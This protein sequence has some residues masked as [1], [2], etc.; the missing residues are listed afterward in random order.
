MAIYPNNKKIINNFN[1]HNKKIFTKKKGKKTKIFLLEFNGW[2]IVHIIFSYLVNYF[3]NEKSCKIVAYES[4]NILNRVSPPWYNK[5]I[6]QLGSIIVLKTFKVFKNFGTDQFIKPK[7]S[8]KILSES[9]K[10]TEKFF[11]TNPNLQNLENL[12]IKGIWIGDLIYD[13]YLKKNLVG[14]VDIKSSNFKVFFKESINFFLFWNDFFLKNKVE[15]ICVCHSVYLTGIPLRIANHKNVSC[16]SLSNMNLVNLSKSISHQKKIN[17]TDIHFRFYRNNFNKLTKKLQNKFLT[18]GKTFLNDLI[19]GRKKYFYLKNKTYSNKIVDIKKYS[20]NN[21]RIKVV[22]FSHDFIDSPH[23]HGNHFFSDFKE[24]FKYLDTVIKKTNYD[25]FI[26]EHPA[27]SDITKKE[28]K[29]LIKNNKNLKLI[30]K[31]FPNDQINKIG[32]KFVLTVYGSVA[33]ELPALGINVI[34]ASKNNPHYGYN[35]CINPKNLTHYKSILLNLDKVKNKINL[36]DL[37]LYNSMKYHM[38]KKNYFFENNEKYFN[39]KNGK[40]LQYTFKMYDY[41]IKDFNLEK[42]KN[43]KENL[44]KFIESKKYFSFT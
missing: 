36:R 41:W 13:S 21:N 1:K 5:Y 43:I 33:S 16:F 40:P 17:G 10:I 35:F 2:P 24:W 22:I 7:Y 30:K 38:Q 37:Y 25:W 15:A 19:A 29:D 4:F 14:T 9:S 8:I 39:F 3:K 32:I 6:W 12:K 23:M 42:H 27:S 26:K 34:N 20:K 11:L 31:N 28:I 18:K 44:K